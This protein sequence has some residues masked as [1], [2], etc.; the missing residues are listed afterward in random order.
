M[1]RQ[2][3][4]KETTHSLKMD[5]ADMIVSTELGVHLSTR[6]AHQHMKNFVRVQKKAIEANGVC[7]GDVSTYLRTKT[8]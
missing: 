6:K 5:D 3:I 1:S 7:V 4:E 8:A 2:S